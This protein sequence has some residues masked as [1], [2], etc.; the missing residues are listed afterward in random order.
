[1]NS[2]KVSLFVILEPL[3]KEENATMKETNWT[4]QRGK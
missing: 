3:D 2:P 1:M 4:K